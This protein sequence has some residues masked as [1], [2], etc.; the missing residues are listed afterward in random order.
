[1]RARAHTHSIMCSV[2]LYVG[3]N[4]SGDHSASETVTDSHQ[5]TPCHNH[6]INL[7]VMETINIIF[8]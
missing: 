8:I 6:N 5:T 3:I 7:I 4:I 1:M 2:V